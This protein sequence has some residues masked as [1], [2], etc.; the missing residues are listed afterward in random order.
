MIR[1]TS[2]MPA[3]LDAVIPMP[4]FEQE[5]PFLYVLKEA[6]GRADCVS[7]T[8][9]LED[10]VIGCIGA[11]LDEE[12]VMTI[13][14]WLSENIKKRPIEFSKKCLLALRFYITSLKPIQTIMYVKHGAEDVV[15]WGSFLG[16]KKVSVV[17]GADG[18]D[19]YK[20]VREK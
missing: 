18:T 10:E 16:F 20:M 3:D 2:A 9:R 19:Y 8:F 12:R 5:K 1:V 6:C 11:C 15:K 14:A 17:T 13:W 4:I 7:H